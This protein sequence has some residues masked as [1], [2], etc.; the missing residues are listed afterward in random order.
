MEYLMIQQ[1]AYATAENL[2]FR[3]TT[4]LKKNLV[5]RKVYH[6]IYLSELIKEDPKVKFLELIYAMIDKYHLAYLNELLKDYSYLNGLL[7]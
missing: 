1:L 7:K 5:L 6:S 2:V 4:N 3:I